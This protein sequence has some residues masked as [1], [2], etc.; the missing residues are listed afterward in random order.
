MT[1]MFNRPRRDDP[2]PFRRERLLC[3]RYKKCGWLPGGGLL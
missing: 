2:R 1:V 3:Y